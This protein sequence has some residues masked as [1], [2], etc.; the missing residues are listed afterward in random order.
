MS[1]EQLLE[2]IALQHGGGTMYVSR[3]GK[4]ST[5]HHYMLA[6][7]CRLLFDKWTCGRQLDRDVTHEDSEAA[8]TKNVNYFFS[9]C[10]KDQVAA[11]P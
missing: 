10:V 5:R 9:H 4:S 7:C 11:N 2:T 1:S 6:K 8:K 3:P